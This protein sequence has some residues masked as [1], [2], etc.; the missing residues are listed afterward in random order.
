MMILAGVSRPD[1]GSLFILLSCYSGSLFILSLG[2]KTIP[3]WVNRT[4][5]WFH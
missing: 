2:L 1:S 4:V 3:V 5:V